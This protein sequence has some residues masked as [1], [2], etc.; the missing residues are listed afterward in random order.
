MT[1]FA[2]L[3]N[4]VYTIT[5]RPDL[6]NETTLAIKRAILKEHAAMDYPRDLLILSTPLTQADPNYYRYA[7][8]LVTLG[9]YSTLRKI[10]NIQEI[11]AT[12]DQALVTFTGYWGELKFE[13]VAADNIFD[14][15]QRER[16]NYFY[17]YGSSINLV[18]VRQIDRIGMTYY[19]KPDLSNTATYSDWL[20]DLYDYVIYTHAAAEIFRVIGK[21]DEY[22]MQLDQ[23]RENRLDIIKSEIGAI[24]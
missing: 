9:L 13:E 5:N 2:D 19:A 8:S 4:S 12:L 17:R 15:Y 21:S 11:P 18:A 7:L 24:G 23:I 20:A 16:I 6:I 3:Q 10:K 1:T 22:R 14:S